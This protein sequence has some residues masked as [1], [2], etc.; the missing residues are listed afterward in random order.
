MHRRVKSG[1]PG[2]VVDAVVAHAGAL[3]E[4]AAVHGRAADVLHAAAAAVG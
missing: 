3:A 4:G 2:V 1:E